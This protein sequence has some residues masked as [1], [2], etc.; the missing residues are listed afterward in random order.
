M[1][2]NALGA[3]RLL[4]LAMAL[5]LVAGSGCSLFGDPVQRQWEDRDRV[6]SCGTVQLDPVRRMDSLPADVEECLEA[7]LTS[8]TG[9]ELVLSYLTTE[10]DPVTEYRR[11][12]PAGTTEVFT[13]AT[14]DQLGDH[15]WLYGSCDHPASAT[16]VA[17]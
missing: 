13:D 3:H 8:R 16:D 9:G 11:V 12:T 6:T 5:V 7:A 15:T 10:G 2:R 4:L 14:K 17:C 1:H